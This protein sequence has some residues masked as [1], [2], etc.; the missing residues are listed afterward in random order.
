VSWAKIF[1]YTFLNR[2]ATKVPRSVTQ[3]IDR[4]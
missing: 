4:Y 1:G 3:G 2:K